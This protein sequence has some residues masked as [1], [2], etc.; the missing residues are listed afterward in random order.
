MSGRIHGVSKLSRDPASHRTVSDDKLTP[1]AVRVQP[2][3]RYQLFDKHDDNKLRRNYPG[4]DPTQHT[5]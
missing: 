1:H 4:I 5:S 2:I 3:L